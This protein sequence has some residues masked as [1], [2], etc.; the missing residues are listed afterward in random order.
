ML[1]ELAALAERRGGGGGGDDDEDALF[2]AATAI[3]VYGEHVYDLMGATKLECQ[4]KV[5]ANGRTRAVRPA[6]VGRDD[7]AHTNIAS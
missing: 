3:E 7:V 5:G 4:L 2:L 6:E 1:D